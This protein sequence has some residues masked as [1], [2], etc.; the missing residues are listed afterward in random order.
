VNKHTFRVAAAIVGAGAFVA[1]GAMSVAAGVSQAQ[2]SMII[3]A[4][5]S[6]TMNT[7]V[8]TYSATLGVPTQTSATSAPAG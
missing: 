7:T 1:M 2:G 5:H 6:A 3:P 4:S 8:Y